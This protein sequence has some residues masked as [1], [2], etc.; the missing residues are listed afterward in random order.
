MSK[1]VN[2]DVQYRVLR[3]LESQPHLSQREIATELALSLGGIN[4]CLRALVQKGQIKVR[5]FRRSDNKI[6]YAYILTPQGLEQKSRLTA[7]FLR[8]KLAEY[9]A[10]KREIDELERDVV[11]TKSWETQ[12][13]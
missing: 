1:P 3:L 11:A 9:E 7:S 5:N 12:V 6:R 13:R 8:R 10:L 4:Y 2:E